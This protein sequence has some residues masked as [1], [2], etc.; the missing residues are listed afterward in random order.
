MAGLPWFKVDADFPGHPKT[1]RLCDRL[2]DANGGMFVIRL[3]AYCARYAPDGRIPDD[4]V[5][6]AAGWSRRKGAF[7]EA[8][9]DAGFLEREGGGFVVHGWEERNGAHVRKAAK[10]AKKPRGNKPRPDHVPPSS[11]DG[12]AGDRRGTE[13]GPA[14]ERE[15]EREREKEAAAAI[16]AAGVPA[17][18]STSAQG[19]AGTA[20]AQQHGPGPARVQPPAAPATDDVPRRLEVVDEADGYAA[21]PPA[22]PLASAFRSALRDRLART[23]LHP[24]GGGRPVWES[25]EA[26][27]RVVPPEEAVQVC[28]DRVFANVRESRRQPGTLAYFAQVLADVALE[29]QQTQTPPPPAVMS[30][31]TTAVEYLD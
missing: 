20:E 30:V 19:A 12:P 29:R 18:T 24:I 17:G 11:L 26:A 2:R 28:A 27:L 22:Y 13:T 3:L 15:T 21:G 5:E 23:A 7:V 9:V 25:L 6:R 31:P 10:D 16:P 8:A 4:M 14:G 1:L